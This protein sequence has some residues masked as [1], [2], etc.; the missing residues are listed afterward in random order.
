MH[1]I[2]SENKW[3]HPVHSCSR[4]F[5]FFKRQRCDLAIGVIEK[6]GNA[7][8]IWVEESEKEAKMR[9]KLTTRLGNFE[10]I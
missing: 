7:W 3:K 9:L 5:G 4:V 10:S 1:V 2:L 8:K 6:E